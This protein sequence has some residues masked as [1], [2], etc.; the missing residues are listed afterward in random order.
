MARKSKF[1]ALVC[2]AVGGAPAVY[3]P[4]T[5][6]GPSANPAETVVKETV[7]PEPLTT[8][9]PDPGAVRG[10]GRSRPVRP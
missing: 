8:L 6:A 1:A 5:A 2:E 7:T 9:V 4:G 10:E 3:L